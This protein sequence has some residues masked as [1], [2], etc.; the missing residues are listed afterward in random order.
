MPA[1]APHSHHAEIHQQL[2][3]L[4]SLR[5]LAREDIDEALL[6]QDQSARVQKEEQRLPD[7]ALDDL[8]PRR[9]RHP[10]SGRIRLITG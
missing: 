7:G 2:G 8:I 5:A 10:P 3:R 1:Q 6:R 4:P 9:H